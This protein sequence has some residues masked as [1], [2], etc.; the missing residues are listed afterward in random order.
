[1]T[2]LN[3]WQFLLLN[4]IGA[5]FLAL[6]VINISLFVDNQE[7][8]SAIAERQQTINQGIGLSRLNN[9]LIRALAT[10]SAQ[11]GDTQIRELLA[12][13]GVTFSVD[14]KPGGAVAVPGGNGDE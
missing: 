1:M 14:S 11:T 6:V 12:A 2:G 7:T 13:H 9:E 8:Q 5:A 4:G 10:A 3:H